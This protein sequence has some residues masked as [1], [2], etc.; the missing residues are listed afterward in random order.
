M[1]ENGQ[2]NRAAIILFGKDPGRFY[3]NTF[4][5]IGRFGEDS[6]DIIFQETEEGNLITLISAVINQLN[7]NFSYKK[8][9]MKGS[10]G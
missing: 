6:T 10:I 8:L 2:L 5:K 4:V 9:L 7:H 3:P 1:A